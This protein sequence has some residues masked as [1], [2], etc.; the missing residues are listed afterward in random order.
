MKATKI[1]IRSK[2]DKQESANEMDN[3]PPQPSERDEE[4]EEDLVL[5]SFFYDYNYN[6]L[7]GKKLKLLRKSQIREGKS[8]I[9]MKKVIEQLNHKQGNGCSDLFLDDNKINGGLRDKD[10]NKLNVSKIY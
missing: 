5:P 1:S 4:A 7:R 8:N 3:M 10:N 9:F 2:E 6:E